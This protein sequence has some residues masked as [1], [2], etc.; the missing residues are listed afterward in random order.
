MNQ[1]NEKNGALLVGLGIFLSRI[2]GLV[3]VRVFAHYFGNSDAGDAFNAALKIP[4]FLQNLFGEGVLSASFIPVYANLIADS[5]NEKQNELNH[6]EAAKVASIIGSL[7]FTMVSLLVLIGIVATPF[8]IDIVAP[9]FKE[10]K[11]LL[12]IQL[13]QIIFPG[14]GL[15]V[16]SAW[17]LGILN[18]HRKFFLSYVAPVIWNAT[19]IITLFIFGSRTTQYNLAIFLSIGLIVG[20][21]LQ[22]AIQLPSALKLLK[23]FRPSLDTKMISVKIIIRNFFPVV[24]S[25]GVIQFSAYIDSMLASLLPMGAVSTLAYAQTLYLLPISLFGMSVSASE[26]PAM[27]ALK[28]SVEEVNLYLRQR[29]EMAL[30]KIAFFIIPSVCA[31][32]FLGNIIIAAILKSGKF[33]QAEVSYVWIVLIGSTIGLLASTLG[34]LYSS[35]FYS[36]KDTKTPLKF[37]FIRVLLTT[38]LGLIFA[39]PMPK[40]LGLD[41]SWGTA[42]LTAS[43][44][45]SGWV[46]FYFLRKSLNRKIGDTS[47]KFSYQLKLWSCA[48]ISSAIG[49]AV[50]FN[51]DLSAIMSAIVIFSFFGFTYFLMTYLF[52]VDES[53]NMIDKI[54]IFL[55]KLFIRIKNQLF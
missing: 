46:E 13:V 33:T 27:S 39:F 26:L 5:H 29:L 40:I 41:A 9:G 36:L 1:K 11:R 37:A 38:V 30:R 35:T 48:I 44:G 45:L 32:I 43:A 23:H 53:K 51:I 22:F 47:L 25:R 55:K 7:L 8:L 18:S 2:S 10:D 50:K 20:S 42:G 49:L 54:Y 12:T 52:K 21:F 17:C 19:L 34:R 3:R 4:N 24:I 15:L 16:M 31:F 6:I 28:G 14:T